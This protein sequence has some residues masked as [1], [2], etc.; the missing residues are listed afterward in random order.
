M[1]CSLIALICAFTLTAQ[2][3]P[4][5]GSI[6]GHVFNL[7]TGEPLRKA[8]VTLTAAEIRLTDVTDAAGKFAFSGLPTATYRLSANR[9]GFLEHAARRPVV[10]GDTAAVTDSE[11]RLPPQGV[12][13][14]RVLDE[15]GDAM[16]GA[17]LTIF[18]Q[19]YRN[20]K[21]LWNSTTGSR[22]DEGGEYRFANLPPGRYIIRVYS[23]GQQAADNRY[24]DH[25]KMFYAP[26]YYPN[27]PNQPAAVPVEVGVGAEIRSLDIH[28][29]KVA[30]PSSP[31]IHVAGKVVGAPPGST[32]D[33]GLHGQ[34]DGACGG[35]GSAGP[36]DYAF[37]MTTH[38]G[39]CTL[40][41]HVFSGGPEAY[42]RAPLSV[43]RDVTG[44]VV[45]LAPAVKIAGSFMVAESTAQGVKLQGLKVWLIDPLNV[46]H[47]IR[48]D[49]S[50]R[51]TSV[52]SLSPDRHLLEVE[53]DWLP[54]GCYL[55]EIRQAGQEISIDAFEPRSSEPLEF[56][57]SNTAGKISGYVVDAD[58][59]PFPIAKVTLIPA[60]PK[61]RA[62]DQS[63]DENSN[64]AIGHLRPGKYT[65]FAREEIDD[66]LWQDPDFRKKYENRGTEV[67]VG[68]SEIQNVQLR[69][70]ES[71]YMK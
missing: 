41:A 10:L 58:G 53:P 71:G 17:G 64:F 18:K 37:D 9:A 20:G 43:V 49:A 66:D 70:I 69:V 40:M 51:F 61:S 45:A 65:L 7:L 26:A 29:F 6:E 33:V 21:K 42:A 57:L 11:I 30:S 50:G 14:G 3:K 35:S 60:N 5:A 68:P 27:A 54:D 62:V 67:T 36:P 48:S 46:S 28:L 4:G 19:V 38:P 34:D 12:I 23:Q 24:G 44:L 16:A 55:R 22:A 15:D 59:K 63:V 1:K 8:T 56:I 32:I 52:E 25:P 39:Q 13:A 2:P 47:L 31:S